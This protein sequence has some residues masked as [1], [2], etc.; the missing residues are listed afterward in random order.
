MKKFLIILVAL[1]SV[2]WYYHNTSVDIT[3]PPVTLPK[4]IKPD[5]VWEALIDLSNYDK[6]NTYMVK[7]NATKPGIKIGDIFQ[8]TVENAK[9]VS[10]NPLVKKIMEP[11]IDV[12]VPLLVTEYEEGFDIFNFN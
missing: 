12:T 4:D 10:N 5:H 1:I 2:F 7:T 11:L 6:W 9:L 8:V 3:A